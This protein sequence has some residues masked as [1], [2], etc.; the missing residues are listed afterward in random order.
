MYY[1]MSPNAWRVADWE[2]RGKPVPP[3]HIIKIKTLKKLA[4][5]ADFFIETGSYMGDMIFAMR[6]QFKKLYSI[7]LDPIL[8][9][10]ASKRFEEN[11]NIQ[12]LKGDSSKV[13]GDLLPNI[14]EKALFWLDGH[15]SEGVTARGELVTPIVKELELISQHIAQNNLNH[16]VA[17]DDAHLFVGEDDY[18][19]ISEINFFVKSN[20]DNYKVKL[21]NNI[22]II[23]KN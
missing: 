14:H 12:I 21:E 17:I 22:I 10:K 7:E 15:Y 3:P 6:G 18:P 20:F 4:K 13:L 16:I 9:K 5:Q 1:R 23:H 19:T 11:H 8:H 2:R